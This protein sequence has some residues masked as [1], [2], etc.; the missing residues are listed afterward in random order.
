MGK[1]ALLA[2]LSALAICANS[3]VAQAPD[4]A[5]SASASTKAQSILTLPDSAVAYAAW[6]NTYFYVAAVVNKP[7]LHG[8]NT[9]AFSDPVKDDSVVFTLQISDSTR[10]DSPDA[11]TVAIAAS[12]MGGVQLYRGAQ[13]TPLFNGMSA[14]NQAM[15]DVMK[16]QDSNK[17]EQARLALFNKIIKFQVVRHGEEKTTHAFMPGYTVEI[18][19]PWVD[20]GVQPKPGLRLGYNIAVLSKSKDSPAVMSW[21]NKVLTPMDVFDPADFGTLVLDTSPHKP[22]ADLAVAMEAVKFAPVIDGVIEPDE[23]SSLASIPITVRSDAAVQL[24]LI[25]TRAARTHP[26]FSPVAAPPPVKAVVRMLPNLA[27]HSEQTL[28]HATL[29]LFDFDYQADAHKSLPV[30][31][32][33]DHGGSLLAQHPIGGTGPWLSYANLDWVRAQLTEA[34]QEGIDVLLP[35]Y[36][37]GNGSTNQYSVS[38]LAM[39]LKQ[40]HANSQE[41]PSIGLFLDLRSVKSNGSITLNALYHTIH[42]YFASLPA[43]SRFAV[44]LSK[45]NG[46]GM[47]Y[48]VFIANSRPL[49]SLPKGWQLTLREWFARDFH[50]TDLILIGTDDFT[51]EGQL[52]GDFNP[53]VDPAA[54]TTASHAW[55]H[56]VS[57]YAGYD[58]TLTGDGSVSSLVR[59][60]QG[61]YYQNSWNRVLSH[62]PEW[63]LIPGWNEYQFGAESA[64]TLEEGFS[65]S[66]LTREFS[67][68]LQGVNQQGAVMQFEDAPRYMV[69]GEICKVHLRAENTGV[70]PWGAQ[71]PAIAAA[72]A[73]RWVRKGTEDQFGAPTPV[74]G[75]VLP[76]HSVTATIPIAAVGRDGNPLPAGE[77][78]LQIGLATLQSAGASAVFIGGNHAG[79]TITIPVAISQSGAASAVHARL[80]D[81]TLPA[82]VEAGSV[83][84]V[85]VSLRNDGK[86]AWPAGERVTLTIDRCS[87]SWAEASTTSA[88]AADASVTLK[89]PVAPGQTVTATV[90]LPVM[91]AD[92]RP[93][94]VWTSDASWK[95]TAHWDIVNPDGR[96]T[97][98][99]PEPLTVITDDFGPRFTVNRTPAELPGGKRLPVL[100]S[101]RNEGPQTWRKGAVSI[102]YHWYYLD[103][104]EYAFNDEIT[105]IGTDV[106][107]QGNITGML[108]WL[109]TPRNNGYYWLVWDL[110]VGDRWATST[111]A[112][113]PNQE[114][115][116][117]VKIIQGQLHF[118][119]L[120]DASTPS[121]KRKENKG[122]TASG[123]DGNGNDF[124]EGELPPYALAN[125]VP[126]G[127]WMPGAVTG[128]TSVRSI[129][130]K[131]SSTAAGTK[132]FISCKGQLLSMGEKPQPCSAVHLL[133]AASGGEVDTQIKLIFKEPVGTSEDL[134]AMTAYPWLQPEENIQHVAYFCRYHLTN[135]GPHTGTCALYDAVIQLPAQKSLVAIR[136]PDEP[137]VKVAAITLVR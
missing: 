115:V 73:Y 10:P 14:F 52:D 15:A 124:P 136:L 81:D 44:P 65:I 76:M 123:F 42:D 131:W 104:T 74:D 130:F 92:G 122:T 126:D 95:Y 39:A 28:P 85:S 54:S 114:T 38:S 57:V 56:V 101:L 97:S 105:P 127:I 119:D 117:L 87:R 63:V 13:L 75:L 53:S 82:T 58:P 36:V 55:L 32:V 121:I 64:P 71:A 77:Y 11:E 60:K 21:S 67:R 40:L 135:A 61:A 72:W 33:E 112:L 51:G 106:P 45:A 5:T 31:G 16:I 24:S 18:A 102:G 86:A 62:S 23:W 129:S 118:V 59:R 1:L 43:W 25:R 132:S 110:K 46:S 79:S 83:Y 108:T 78:Q 19:V 99:T 7:T 34:H 22:T 94:S 27:A 12:A 137:T 134:F 88:D 66:D 2:A 125:I 84:P 116:Q 133:L 20:I 70:E 89:E 48:P 17:R 103:G 111:R 90:Q 107:P 68:Q 113:R 41:T 128:P 49:Q 37:F 96:G 69:G 3:A 120:A 8:D 50:H 91:K 9:S 93:L 30:S 80:I 4:V 100:L 47:A 29:A 109:N 26:Q 98:T 6:D 35:D